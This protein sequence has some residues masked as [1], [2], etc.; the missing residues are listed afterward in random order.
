[1]QW[2]EPES[3]NFEKETLCKCLTMKV[4]NH[5]NSLSTNVVDFL[6]TEAIKPIRFPSRHALI[7][8]GVMETCTELGEVPS[9]LPCRKSLSQNDPTLNFSFYDLWTFSG[10]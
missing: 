8:P 2:T 3:R 6:S 7:H 1:M 9:S 10:L 4:I 5:L